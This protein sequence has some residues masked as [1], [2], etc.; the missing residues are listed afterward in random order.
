MITM[1]RSVVLVA[2]GAVSTVSA[3]SARREEYVYNYDIATLAAA[4]GC[5]E[6]AACL[7][8]ALHCP[9]PLVA[10]AVNGEGEAAAIPSRV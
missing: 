2:L 1:F 10:G 4:T 3:A 9:M 7:E 8:A 5:A 6:Q